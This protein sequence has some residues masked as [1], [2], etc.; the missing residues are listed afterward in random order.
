MSGDEMCMM[1]GKYGG[2]TTEDGGVAGIER[3]NR[4]LYNDVF[5]MMIFSRI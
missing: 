5:I 4:I 1:R 3:K 2:G